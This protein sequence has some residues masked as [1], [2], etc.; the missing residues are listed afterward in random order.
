MCAMRKKLLSGLLS[1]VLLFGIF[2]VP[3]WALEPSDPNLIDGIDVS[4]WQGNINFQAVREAGIEVVYIRTSLGSN[5]TDPYWRQNYQNAK[6]AGLRVGFYHYLTARSVE[7]AKNQASYFVSVIGDAVPDCR[8]AMDFESFGRLDPAQVNAVARTFLQ[9]A[10]ELS[11]YGMV[12]YSNA[13]DTVEVFDRTL[14]VY[15]LW[16]ANYGVQTPSGGGSW[17]NWVGFQYSST[18]NVA[19]ISGNVDLDYFTNGIFLEDSTVTPSAPESSGTIV[20]TI[21]PGDTL[22]ELAVLYGTT[23]ENLAAWN[24]IANP[25]LIY[26]GEQLRILQGSSVGN[27]ASGVYTVQLG[28]TLWGIAQRYGTTVSVLAA[29]N[30]IANPDLIY[31]G[32]VLRIG[33]ADSNTYTVQPG[34]TLWEIAQQFGTTVSALAAA[35]GIVNPDL[36]YPGQVLVL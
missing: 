2:A 22:W 17:N 10:E 25:N 11:G 35:N 6:A 14:S 3:V 33:S 29:A 4:Q 16:I 20:I 5:Y 13:N 28:D 34:D 32:E 12:V 7:E 24:N 19:G 15:P 30:G 23:V 36:I 21:Q 18:G 1:V 31:P 9:T 8:L 26:A 27:G